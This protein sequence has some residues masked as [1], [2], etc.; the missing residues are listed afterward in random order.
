[1]RVPQPWQYR[2]AVYVND[3]GAAAIASWHDA[4][5]LRTVDHHVGDRAI[6]AYPP[7]SQHNRRH[8]GNARPLSSRSVHGDLALGPAHADAEAMAA[9]SAGVGLTDGAGVS[10][11]GQARAAILDD[12]LRER[13]SHGG[14]VEQAVCPWLRLGA[15]GLATGGGLVQAQGEVV[16]V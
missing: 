11:P 13:T 8:E 1:M 16:V 3:L 14:S 4:A 15:N 10:E 12:R 2:R 5:H 6:D 7:V 9:A